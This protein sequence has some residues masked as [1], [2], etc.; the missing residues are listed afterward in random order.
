MEKK[1]EVNDFSSPCSNPLPVSKS[2]GAILLREGGGTFTRPSM[3]VSEE[4]MSQDQD[5]FEILEGKI[6]Q[7]MTVYDS[8]KAE[9]VALGGQ[10]AESKAAVKSLEEKMSR[11]SHERERA[12]EKI[13]NLLKKLERLIPSNR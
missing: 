2:C 12:R 6:N 3:S 5:S 1:T 10:L 9:N 4:E 8:L 7:L 13:E 11:L